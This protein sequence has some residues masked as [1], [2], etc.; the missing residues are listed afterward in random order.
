MPFWWARRRK[1]WYTPWWKRRNRYKRRKYPWRRRRKRNR[2][3]TRRRR[4]RRRRYKVRRKRKTIPI[5][6]WQPDRI[7]RCKIKGTGILVA[8]AQGNQYHCYTNVKGDYTQPKAPG[9]G[10]FATEIYSLAYLYKE[11][12][13]HRNIW[14]KSN[15][16]TDLVRYQGCKFTFYRHATTDFIVSYERQGPFTLNVN[17]YPSIH[18]Q[19]MLLNR[20]HKVIKSVAYNPTGKRAVTLKIGPPKQMTTKWF[21]QQDFADQHL[22]KLNAAAMNLPYSLYGPNTQSPNIT[23]TALNI[24]FFKQHNWGQDK[25]NPYLPYQGFPTTK[26]VKFID[27]NGRT[28]SPNPS[29]YAQSIDQKTGWFQPGVLQAVKV[30][31]ND[32][33]L[34]ERP[35]CLGRY[36]PIEDTGKGNRVWLTSI[37]SDKSWQPSGDPELIIGELPLYMCFFGIW[38][39]VVKKK[40]TSEFLKTSMFV[41]KSDFIKILT[42]TGQTVWPIVDLSFIQGKMPYDETPTEQD[43]KLWYPTAYKQQVIINTIVESGPYIPKYYNLP[44]S[45]WQLPFSYTFYF[46][47]GGP[48]VSDQLVQDP[49]DQDKYPVPDNLT[50][51]IQ[52]TNPLKQNCKGLLRSWDFRRGYVTSSALKRMRENLQTDSSLES[53][54]SETP[55]KKKKITAEIPCQMQE[56]EDLQTCL[57]SLCEKDTFPDQTQDLQQLIYN[58]YKQQQDLKHNIFKLLKHLKSKQRQLQ[59]NT[60]LL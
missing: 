44:S 34:H 47:W 3:F 22:L 17:T 15:D 52:I 20:H 28:V 18:P 12:Q 45:T 7:L 43:I 23:I 10:S 35:I 37:I 4:R 9:G 57:L 42:P 6:Q 1:P 13:A 11:W 51:A 58:Q 26:S 33:T 50:Q 8:G 27:K 49:K 40:G 53:D 5:R 55:K 56:E 30:T 46:K 24:S 59:M 60:G 32:Q 21:F 14:T 41:I 16:W 38:D 39:Y 54:Q 25:G 31:D 48:Q 2:R 29:N 19:N 36:N